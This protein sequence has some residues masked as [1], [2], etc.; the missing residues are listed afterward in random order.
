MPGS[1]AGA[2]VEVDFVTLGF[3]MT[4]AEAVQTWAHWNNGIEI[5]LFD[6]SGTI[7]S[8]VAGCESRPE[9]SVCGG[10]DSASKSGA[11]CAQ[12]GQYDMAGRQSVAGSQPLSPAES[13]EA[14]NVKTRQTRPLTPM[15]L[16]RR[17]GGLTILEHPNIHGV[18][19]CSTCW[20]RQL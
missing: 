6:T 12:R 5:T 7:G 9:C 8:A 10:R 2:M 4:S 1:V 13:R 16:F 3:H 15:R 18:V 19:R 17:T 20:R 14:S 11:S